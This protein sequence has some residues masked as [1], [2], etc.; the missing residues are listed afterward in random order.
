LIGLPLETDVDLITSAESQV[1]AVPAE[2]ATAENSA[3]GKSLI[4]AALKTRPEIR[5]ADFRIRASEAG[6]KAAKAGWYPQVYLAGN[7]YYL[8]PNQRL[9]PA[10]DKF[11]GTWDIGI[12]VSFDVWNWGQT[13]SQADQ[14]RAQLDQAK[15]ARKLLEDQAVL[16]VTQSR[17]ALTQAREKIRVAGQ[18]VGQAE[19]NLRITRE[20]F[21]QGLA[22]NMD[23]LDAELFLLQAKMNRTQ[24]AIDLALAQARLEKALGE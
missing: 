13:K 10:R 15:D 21:K 6:V 18:A 9:M 22:L 17:L 23:V 11:Y 2:E 1:S 12:A 3:A 14:A 7:Y 20:R 19:E 4:D 16:E 8:R 5:S 24:A